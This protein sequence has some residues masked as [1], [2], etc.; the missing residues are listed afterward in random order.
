[1]YE[2]VEPWETL[3]FLSYKKFYIERTKVTSILRSN[4]RLEPEDFQEKL[5]TVDNPFILP[6]SKVSSQE[7]SRFRDTKECMALRYELESEN[8]RIRNALRGLYNLYIEKSGEHVNMLDCDNFSEEIFRLMLEELEG[9]AENLEEAGLVVATK[10]R[11][12]K[13][14]K[15]GLLIAYLNG[16]YVKNFAQV[17]LHE[18]MI[19]IGKRETLREDCIADLFLQEFRRVL[20]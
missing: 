14:I 6:Y 9:I 17:L 1:M 16:K 12:G 2:N 10:T 8:T 5:E 15:A 13:I 20:T 18:D 19:K 11:M 4:A 3:I 7:L